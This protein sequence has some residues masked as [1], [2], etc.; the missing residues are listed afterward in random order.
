MDEIDGTIEI[1]GSIYWRNMTVDDATVYDLKVN[2][3]W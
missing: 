2:K 1:D 3:K